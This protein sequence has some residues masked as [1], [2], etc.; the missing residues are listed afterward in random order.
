[1]LVAVAFGLQALHELAV[2]P[3]VAVLVAGYV[4]TE[5]VRNRRARASLGR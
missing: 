3:V 4:L 1:M 5:R 2:L